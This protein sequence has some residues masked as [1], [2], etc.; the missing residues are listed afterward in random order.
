MFHLSIFV[1]H[2]ILIMSLQQGGDENVTALLGALEISDELTIVWDSESEPIVDAGGPICQV[3]CILSRCT[4][5]TWPH[6]PQL[7]AC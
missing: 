6:K 4:C 1:A 3:R 7:L 5:M 2:V